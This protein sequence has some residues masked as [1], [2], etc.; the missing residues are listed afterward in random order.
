[1][2]LYTFLYIERML[3]FALRAFRFLITFSLNSNSNSKKIKIN[4]FV[5]IPPRFLLCY[6]SPLRFFKAISRWSDSALS[7]ILNFSLLSHVS[8]FTIPPATYI[9]RSI[10]LLRPLVCSRSILPIHFLR[11]I[12]S[13][14]SPL[15]FPPC[16]WI[17]FSHPTL[18]FPISCSS[19]SYCPVEVP[20]HEHTFFPI[21]FNC[22]FNRSSCCLH[23]FTV[24]GHYFPPFIAYMNVYFHASFFFS[25]F[26]NPQFHPCYY[27]P[28]SSSLF[29]FSF[30]PLTFP[31][32]LF[33]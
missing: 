8:S 19:F 15:H 7:P 13:V 32:V 22:V 14:S 9:F 6:F 25:L 23:L 3:Y 5:P 31:F 26:F 18:L 27:S 21:F 12:P 28:G 20:S 16:L 24:H 11:S 1:L 17:F 4:S 10:P 33:R 30:C 29:L 2:P